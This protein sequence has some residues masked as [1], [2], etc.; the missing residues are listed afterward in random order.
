MV[1]HTTNTTDHHQQKEASSPSRPA[2][3]FLGEPFM[4]IFL[5][6][7]FGPPGESSGKSPR[8]RFRPSGRTFREFSS[9][10][11][12]TLLGQSSGKFLVEM[13]FRSCKRTCRGI[14]LVLVRVSGRIFP[15]FSSQTIIRILPCWFAL[16]G[17][18]ALVPLFHVGVLGTLTN[19]FSRGVDGGAKFDQG[20]SIVVA[21]HP[22]ARVENGGTRSGV[23]RSHDT[24]EAE[25][26]RCHIRGYMPRERSYGKANIMACFFF[27][28]Y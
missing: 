24:L 11:L 4:I 18:R 25:L 2:G 23:F 7:N 6:V 1:K 28:E 27:V 21:S 10:K 9:N 17:V 16:R 13:L 15:E 14:Y 20:V 5:E 8:G 26:Y 19:V 12:S 22:S 3:F